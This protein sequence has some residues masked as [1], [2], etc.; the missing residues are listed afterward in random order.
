MGKNSRGSPR[1]PKNE[2]DSA[3]GVS[4]GSRR[5]REVQ[6]INSHPHLFKSAKS[7]GFAATKKIKKLKRNLRWVG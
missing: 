5:F 2:R 1:R 4:N 3:V 7:G 6:C